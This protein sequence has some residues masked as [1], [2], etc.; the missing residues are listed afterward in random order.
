MNFIASHSYKRLEKSAQHIFKLLS[1]NMH[2]NTFCITQVADG[3]QSNVIYVFNRNQVL[4]ESG[5]SLPLGDA[6]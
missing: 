3:V 4:F 1:K 2:V 5:I 6:Y